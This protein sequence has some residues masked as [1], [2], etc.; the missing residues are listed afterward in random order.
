MATYTVVKGDTFDSIAQ[1]LGVS[2]ADLKKANSS[3]TNT[4]QITPG[5]TIHVPGD[6]PNTTYHVK[7][8]DTGD[9]IASKDNTTFQKLEQLNPKVNWNALEVGQTVI[10]PRD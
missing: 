2:D 7:S 1:R 9:S 5:E 4:N 6:A 8:G 3:I 10:V